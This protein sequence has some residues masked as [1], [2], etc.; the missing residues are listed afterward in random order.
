MYVSTYINIY[1]YTLGRIPSL[2]R[3]AR[4]ACGKPRESGW[5]RGNFV[6]LDYPV[7]WFTT[8][9]LKEAVKWP[10]SIY[11]KN[12]LKDDVWD[13]WALLYFDAIWFCLLPKYLLVFNLASCHDYLANAPTPRARR[14]Y[15]IRC[16][17]IY[18]DNIP[19]DIHHHMPSKNCNMEVS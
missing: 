2:R 13:T 8:V 17:F 19:N 18:E 10:Q 1:I 15:P 12:F 9:I 14:Y 3:T 4:A 16:W 5:S 6:F 7:Q 11:F